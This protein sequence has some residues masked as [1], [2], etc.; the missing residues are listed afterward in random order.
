M[1]DGDAILRPIPRSRKGHSFV[2][3]VLSGASGLLVDVVHFSGQADEPVA[4]CLGYI[5]LFGGWT[6]NA[7]GIGCSRRGAVDA[8]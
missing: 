7:L 6:I 1:R 8:V 5:A 3:L 4:L 2:I